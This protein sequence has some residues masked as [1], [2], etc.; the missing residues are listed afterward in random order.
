[1][2]AWDGYFDKRAAPCA[3]Q[4]EGKVGDAGSRGYCGGCCDSLMPPWRCHA[5]SRGAFLLVSFRFLLVLLQRACERWHELFSVTRPCKARDIHLR[6]CMFFGWLLLLLPCY[7]KAPPPP[8]HH[9]H[10]HCLPPTFSIFSPVPQA[11]SAESERIRIC[12]L[13]HAQNVTAHGRVLY[14]SGIAMFLPK[15]KRSREVRSCLLLQLYLPSVS[16]P[17][18]SHLYRLVS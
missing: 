4:R 3:L 11:Y 10:H 9:H 15:K 13:V 16:C 7:C 5:D 2:C 1:M 8:P 12:M 6:P 14:F 18:T 17:L